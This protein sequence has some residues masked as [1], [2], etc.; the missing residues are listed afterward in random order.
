MQ[1]VNQWHVGICASSLHSLTSVSNNDKMKM[2]K[3]AIAHVLL[4]WFAEKEAKCKRV[5]GRLD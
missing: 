5:C 4:H 3:E 2:K 1:F